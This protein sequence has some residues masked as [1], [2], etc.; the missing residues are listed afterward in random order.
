MYV[1]KQQLIASG[2]VSH[3]C[4]IYGVRY[5]HGTC[6]QQIASGT[7]LITSLWYTEQIVMKLGIHVHYVIIHPFDSHLHIVLH[8]ILAHAC[9]ASRML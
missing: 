9:V 8:T 5:N 2:N 7:F 6:K 4:S 3:I 1:C